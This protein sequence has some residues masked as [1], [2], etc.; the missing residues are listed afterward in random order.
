[1]SRPATGTVETKTLSDGTRVFKLR[2]HADGRREHE[3]LHE[4]RNCMRLRRRRGTSGPR[5]SSSRT[6][7]RASERASGA[8]GTRHRRSRSER[9]PTFHEYASAWLE[10]K[11]DG[12]LGD[13]P[14]GRNTESDYRSRLAN[15]LLPFF[16]EYRLDEIDAELCLAFKAH[17]LQE[18]AELRRAIEAAPTSRPSRAT[19]P[20]ARACDRS[21]SSSTASP[22]SSMR[23]ST[24]GI[25]R[26]TR[27]A[28]DGCASRCPSRPGRSSRWTSS[29]PSPTRPASRTAASRGRRSRLEPRPDRPPRRSATAGPPACGPATSPRSSASRRRPSRTTCAPASR[30]AGYVHRPPR[31]RR[32]PRRLGRARQRALRHAHPRPAPARGERRALPDPRREDRSG[33]PRGPGEPG[34]TRGARR[35]RRPAAGAPTCR[36]IPTPTSSRTPRRPHEPPASGELVRA[37]AGARVVTPGR[38]RSARASQHDAAHAAPHVHLGRAAR[39]PLRRALG[40]APGRPRRL[41]DDD[42]RL[43]AAAAA[44]RA[45]ARRGVRRARA[46]RHASRLYG[47]PRPTVNHRDTASIGESKLEPRAPTEL[48][49]RLGTRASRLR[50]RH[51]A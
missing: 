17:K 21:A 11:I 44:R 28:A 31:H 8:S 12:V 18:A 22:R 14:I 16:G 33:H 38:A 13:R 34:S 10:A 19:R 24:T 49:T 9:V 43:R 15:H 7:S 32:D 3:V 27:L 46:R 29:S 26:A 30:G 40:H 39:E 5:Q 42:G 47:R 2:F 25:C 35:P 6:S 51:R 45:P 50:R 48:G 37:A 4:R 23:P 36:R 41:E 1:M 20:A